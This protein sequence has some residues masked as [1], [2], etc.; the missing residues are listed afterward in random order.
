ML[1]KACPKCSGDLFLD[2]DHYGVFLQCFQCGLTLERSAESDIKRL[3]A[4]RTKRQAA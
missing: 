4:A 2:K 1:F 3:I